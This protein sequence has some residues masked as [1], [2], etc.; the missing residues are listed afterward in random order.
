MEILVFI[1]G[2]LAIGTVI[3][4][5]VLLT[6]DVIRKYRT[7]RNSKILVADIGK[8]IRDMPNKEKHTMSFSDFENYKDQKII[9]EYDPETNEVVKTSIVDKGMDAQ[10]TSFVDRCG[11]YIIVGD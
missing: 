6:A 7:R 1:L 9:G 10:V 5:G 3:Y 8:F 4:L 2:A 11:G